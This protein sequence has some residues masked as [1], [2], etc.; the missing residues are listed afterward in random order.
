MFGLQ[1]VHEKNR[2]FYVERGKFEFLLA[3]EKVLLF[4]KHFWGRV[5]ILTS[6]VVVVIIVFVTVLGD[7]IGVASSGQ[8][9]VLLGRY[10]AGESGDLGCIVVLGYCLFASVG[11]MERIGLLLTDCEGRGHIRGAGCTG[12]SKVLY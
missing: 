8:T 9:G 10:L 12:V 11:E 4:T 5:K 7:C 2:L 6:V 1:T 3:A